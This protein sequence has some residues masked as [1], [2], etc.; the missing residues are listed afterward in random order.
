MMSDTS[1][2]W[3]GP[4]DKPSSR[5]LLVLAAILGIYGIVVLKLVAAG[6]PLGHDEAV[7]ALKSR[8]IRVGGTSAWYWNDYR[9][10]GLP[11]ALQLTW[12]IRG[13]EP[14][15]RMT[16]A[17]FGALGIV[18]TWLLGRTLFDSRSG[19]IG[20]AGLAL[21]S[22]WLATST[23]VWPDVP[24]AVLGLAAIVIIVFATENE[25]ASWWILAAGPFA[26]AAVVVRYGALVPMGIGAL[27]VMIWRRRA[28]LKSIPQYASLALFTAVGSLLV[29]TVPGITGSTVSPLSSIRTLQAENNFPI[30]RGIRDYIRQGD[31]IVG[32]YAG[33]LL[34]VG[35]A[36][37]ALYA[38]KERKQL[39][40]WGLVMAIAV[41][42]TVALAI[43][44]HGE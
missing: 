41:T 37:A 36:L 29:L 43:I 3:R 30:T 5:E 35:L 28:I 24:G 34:I 32:G 16:V 1:R 18:I 9:A 6:A 44:L 11:L 25:R 13:T 15:F 21:F 7:Y 2:A 19:L 42:T 26:V 17:A 27:I 31:F 22:P 33:L 14:F 8:H 12:L 10:P 39:S 40:S 23:S 38:I 4:G 20:A